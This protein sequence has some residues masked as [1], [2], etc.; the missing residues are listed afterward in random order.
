[1]EAPPSLAGAAQE[2][3]SPRCFPGFPQPKIIPLFPGCL[4]PNPQHL[5][6]Y[7]G[8]MVLAS[9]QI[10]WR[11][12]ET[13][14]QQKV[15]GKQA[16]LIWLEQEEEGRRSSSRHGCVIGLVLPVLARWHRLISPCLSQGTPGACEE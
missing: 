2:P 11:P 15:K 6:D 8:S 14:S 5:Q 7:T 9:A 16:C 4:E 3:L 12:Q 10:L 1:M 13:Q